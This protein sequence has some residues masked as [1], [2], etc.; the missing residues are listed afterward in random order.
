MKGMKIRKLLVAFMATC[1]AAGAV[2]FIQNTVSASAEVIDDVSVSMC[3]GAAVRITDKNDHNGIKFEMKLSN[4][5]YGKLTA[6][7]D[8]VSFGMLIAPASYIEDYGALSEENVFGTAPTYDYAVYD[9][10]TETWVYNGKNGEVVNEVATPVRIVNIVGEDTFTYTN[11]ANNVYFHGSLTNV[12]DE[13]IAREFVGRGYIAA[14]KGTDTVYT[15]ADY[16]NNP[17]LN[18]CL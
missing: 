2:Y 15:F 10:E 14:T 8:S 9:E 5:D 13:N 3:E 11:D 7:Y 12:K 6:E 1:C 18:K 17:K 4:T 16:Y